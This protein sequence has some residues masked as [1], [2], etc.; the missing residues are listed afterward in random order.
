MLAVGPLQVAYSEVCTADVGAQGVGLSQNHRLKAQGN[1]NFE[2]S[3][4]H[5]KISYQ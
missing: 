3:M 5:N 4:E 2:K 1:H